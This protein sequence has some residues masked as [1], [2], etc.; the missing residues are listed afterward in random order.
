M[1]VFFLCG[2]GIYLG[3]F[4]RLN[5]WD[6]FKN[7]LKIAQQISTSL[8]QEKAWYITIGFGIFL[9]ILFFIYDSFFTTEQNK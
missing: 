6:I 3:R 1:F 8:L 7:P 4:L 2:F 9:W 5:S